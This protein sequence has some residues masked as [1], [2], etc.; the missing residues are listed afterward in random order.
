LATGVRIRD[1]ADLVATTD[2]LAEP[3]ILHGPNTFMKDS[4]YQVYSLFYEMVDLIG[5]DSPA[6]VACIR[7]LLDVPWGLLCLLGDGATHYLERSLFKPFLRCCVDRWAEYEAA[8]FR[9]GNPLSANRSLW[10]VVV[11][12]KFVLAN[13][14]VPIEELNSPSFARRFVDVASRRV[15]NL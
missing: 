1:L 6:P 2:A 15:E 8:G 12:P 4:A 10:D 9:Y 13:L 5:P 3:I 14:G 7:D 11:S